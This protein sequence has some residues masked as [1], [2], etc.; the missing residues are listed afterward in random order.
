[1][2]RSV[3]GALGG[4]RTHNNAVGGHDFIQLDYECGSAVFAVIILR[5]SAN[6]KFLYVAFSALP[7]SAAQLFRVSLDYAQQ[8]GYNLVHRLHGNKLV[9]TVRIVPARTDIGAGQTHK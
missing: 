2:W 4:A 1:M 9:K 3:F 6:C 8:Y 5:K 7:L